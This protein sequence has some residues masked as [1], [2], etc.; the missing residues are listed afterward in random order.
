MKRFFFTV[1]VEE[2]FDS[3]L[4]KSDSTRINAATDFVEPMLFLLRLLKKYEIR[5]TF[6][7]L[8]RVAGKYPEIVNK[9]IRSG[10]EIALHGENHDNILDLGEEKFRVMLRKM[11]SDF[12]EKLNVNLVGYR[13]PHFGINERGLEILTEEGFSYDASIVPS[14]PIPGWYGNPRAPLR[15]YQINKKLW[16]YPASVH[17]WFRIPGGGGYYFRNLGFHWT[18]HVLLAMLHKH[19]YAMFYI[20]PWELSLKNPTNLDVPF[21]TFRRTGGWTRK[22]LEKLL[23][24]ITALPDVRCQ[25]MLEDANTSR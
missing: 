17:P 2:W 19:H 13:A 16:E 11:R 18:K 20:H 22:N 10:H 9:V 12:K 1:D 25:T 7:F 6:F 14:L 23:Q 4:I 8:Y 5:A 15:P 24:A 21:Y 3:K